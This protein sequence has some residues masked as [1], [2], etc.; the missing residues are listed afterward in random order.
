MKL[1]EVPP[2]HARVPLLDLRAMHDEI[3]PALDDIWQRSIEGSAFIGGNAVGAFETAWAE[4][5]GR[6]HAIGVG[7]GTDAIALALRALGIGPEDEVIVPANT[8]IATAEGVLMTGATPRFVDVDP[9]THLI[10]REKVEGAIGPQTKAFVVVDL[11]GN[12]PDMDELEDVARRHHLMLVE[13]AA[14]AHGSTWRGRRAGSFGIAGCF[15]FYPGKNLGAFGDAGAVVTDDD[16]LA[17][18]IR[19]LADHGR[20]PE[21]SDVHRVVGINSRLDAVQAEVLSAKLP[22]LDSWNARRCMIA[23]KYDAALGSLGDHVGRL[24]M[25]DDVV[26]SYHHYV[27]RV[28]ERDRLQAQLAAR[29]IDT[30]I[31]YAIPCHLQ[32]PYRRYAMAPL[33][34]AERL[35]SEILSLPMS[36][37]LT[38]DQIDLVSEVIARFAVGGLGARRG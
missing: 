3:R 8:F 21:R 4:F 20:T 6:R 29:G 13:D 25:D 10:T 11:H 14:Q 27:L 5:C 31:H 18:Q 7:N 16:K 34:V 33:P 36:P 22:F 23:A 1:E 38:E 17:A 19:S 32:E 9:Q 2:T 37:H 35:A 26:S 12:M 28:S 30:G 24:I 15:S